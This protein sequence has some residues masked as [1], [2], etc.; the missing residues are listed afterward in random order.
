LIITRCLLPTK[1]NAFIASTV[2]SASSSTVSAVSREAHFGKLINR[3][4]KLSELTS[5]SLLCSLRQ[6]QW[7]I[8]GHWGH[9][10]HWACRSVEVSK[11]RSDRNAQNT[12]LV[13]QI[14][15]F[16]FGDFQGLFFAPGLNLGCI[17]RS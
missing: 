9:W 16:L 5:I 6:A 14:G 10:G 13:Q 12:R 17:T 3:F 7:A 1:W 2:D 8:W 11:C 4:G 15:S